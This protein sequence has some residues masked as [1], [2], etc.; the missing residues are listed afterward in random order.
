[1]ASLRQLST[2]QLLAECRVET[3]RGPGP[4]GQKKNKTSSAVR[5]THV[6]SGISVSAG[7]SRSQMRNRQSAINRL[8]HRIALQVR[9]EIDLTRLPDLAAVNVPRRSSEYPAAMGGILDTLEHVGWSVSEAAKLIGVSTGRLVAFLRDDPPLWTEVNLRRK[10][11]G[12][13]G[14]NA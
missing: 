13:R 10:Q 11:L 12:L 14:L 6:P 9:E 5:L 7:E 8:W 3:F 2:E 1:M 4:G